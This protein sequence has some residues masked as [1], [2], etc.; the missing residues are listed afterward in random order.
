M[1][2][3]RILGRSI[4]SGCRSVFRNFSLSMA[5]IT[6]T[7]ITLVLVSIGILLTHN[8]NNISRNLENEV[9]IVIFMEPEIT[10]EELTE[11]EA[12][13]NTVDNV[14][15]VEFRSR[16]EIKRDYAM[17]NPAYYT[18]IS[19]WDEGIN[20]FLNAFIITVDNVRNIGETA[21]TIRNMEQVHSIHYG[22]SIANDL[23]R[24]LTVVQ[25]S[26]Y[27]LV[28]ALILVTTFLIGNTIKITI[29]SRRNEIEIMRLVGTNNA[30]IR[31]PFFFEGL[32][33]GAVG[34]LIPILITIFG[35]EYVYQ[36]AGR[37]PG[38]TNILGVLELVPPGQVVLS[39]SLILL[40]IGSVVGMF[41]SVRAVR[42][43]L[44][45]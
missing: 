16:E 21:T 42:K 41:G 13:L 45:V 28:I 32:L 25:N 8:L 3:F 29:F 23:V 10:D 9:T 4:T 37:A 18:I 19:S 6:C 24:I 22:E 40:I 34:S 14:A 20:P 5:S 17:S 38:F 2:L 7:M 43:Y 1:R 11:K 31:L 27:V 15:E 30:V 36:A 12:T 35:Y 39:T 33:L 26:A 44:K